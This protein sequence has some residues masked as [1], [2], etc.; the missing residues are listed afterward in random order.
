[1][2]PR[3]SAFFLLLTLPAFAQQLDTRDLVRK[4]ASF[5]TNAQTGQPMVATGYALV[6]GVGNFKDTRLNALRFA[7]SD[8]Q[9][10]FRVLISPQA[11]YIPQNVHKLIGADATLANVK[12]ELEQW[13]PTK[14][15]EQDRVVIYFAGHGYV[16]EGKGKGYLVLYDTNL[17]NLTG[18]AYPMATLGQVVGTSIRSKWK[19]LFTDACHSGVIR[20]S[21]VST[22]GLVS[23]NLDDVGTGSSLFTFSASRGDERSFEDPALGGGHG[24]FTYFLVQGLQGQAD[25]SGDGVVTAEELSYYVTH[26]VHEYVSKRQQSQNPNSGKNEYDGGMILASDVSKL[27]MDSAMGM[28]EGRIVVQSNMDD[29]EIRLNGVMKGVAAR[30][31]P[32]ELPGLLPG[33]YTIVGARRGYEPDGP[34]TIQ[35]RPG[36][37]TTVPIN[38][39][40]RK[41][42]DKKAEDIFNQGL[43]LYLRQGNLDGYKQAAADFER[44]LKIDGKYSAAAEYAARAYNM[45]GQLDEAAKMFQKALAIDPDF[46]VARVDYAGMLVDRGDSTEAIRQASE[47]IQREP[48]NALAYSHM[49]GA[50]FYAGDF[51]QCVSSARK[52]IGFDP[53]YAASHLWLGDCLRNQGEVTM[54]KA[55][56]GRVLAL[57]NHDSGVS[58]QLNYWVLGSLFGIGSRKKASRQDVNKDIQNLAYFGL[59]GC[60]VT[61]KRPDAAISDCQQA[62]KYDSQDPYSYYMLGNAYLLKFNAAQPKDK[63]LLLTAKTNFDKM[64]SLNSD[65]AESDAARTYLQKIDTM[66][67]RLH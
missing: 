27:K 41:N 53:K 19:A 57:S 54:A 35:V 2:L 33:D 9:E 56:Y 17:D 3:A 47:A 50:Y 38:I 40:I 20:Q 31:T 28:K 37:T 12:R 26:Q 66:L 51:D 25:E 58:G 18:T 1:V 4:P 14:A 43:N 42:V 21:T 8:A 65:L 36:E 67:K 64:L 48:R 16:E 61:A 44:S 15:G 60:E 22:N 46:T 52:S 32:L 13:L 62:L 39:R 23:Q 55:E 30:S 24:I 34:K 7:E 29:V 11:G 59:C 49:A 63:G 5:S 45:A 6:I 10:M